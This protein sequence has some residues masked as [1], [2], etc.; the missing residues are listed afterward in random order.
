MPIAG[1]FAGAAVAD[2][3]SHRDAD[4]GKTGGRMSHLLIGM[5]KTSRR[6]RNTDLAEDF[7]RRQGGC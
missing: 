7:V 6:F 4:H 3:Q 1:G 5:T 2:L